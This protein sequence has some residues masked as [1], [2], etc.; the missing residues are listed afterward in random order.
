MHCVFDGSALQPSPAPDAPAAVEQPLSYLISSE[1]PFAVRPTLRVAIALCA[2]LEAIHRA[3]RVVGTLHPRDILVSGFPPVDEQTPTVRIVEK[4]LSEKTQMTE[5][6]TAYLSPEVAR[7]QA[8]DPRSDVYSVGAILYEMLSG[9]SPR[10]AAAAPRPQIPTMLEE[11]IRHSMAVDM[12]ARQSSIPALAIEL[13]TALWQVERVNGQHAPAPAPPK[14]RFEGRSTDSLLG[15]VIAGRYRLLAKLGESGLGTVFKSESA[16]LNRPVAINV[17]PSELSQDAVFI[18]R[19][20]SE[21]QA[22][23]RL[24]HPHAAAIYDFG[25]TRDGYAYLVSELVWGEPLSAILKREGPLPLV[26]ALNIAAQIAEAVETAHRLGLSHRSLKPGRVMVSRGERDADYVKVLGFGLFKMMP[27]ITDDHLT[28]AGVVIAAPEYMAPEQLSGEM[29]DA[30]SDI[31]SLAT[32]LYEMLTGRLPFEGDSL[33]VRAVRQMA[34]EPVSLRK[35]APHVGR[36]IEKAVMKGLAR[37]PEHRQASVHDFWRELEAAARAEAIDQ[38]DGVI[39][40]TARQSKSGRF[41]VVA[42][43]SAF[44]SRP[45]PH[46]GSLLSWDSKK[47]TT[48]LL[49]RKAA[50]F[51]TNVGLLFIL[52]IVLGLGS[53]AL[54]AAMLNMAA[55]ILLALAA[56]VWVWAVIVLVHKL[57]KAPPPQEVTASPAAAQLRPQYADLPALNEHKTSQ[58]VAELRQPVEQ[59]AE[60]EATKKCPTCG[61][62]LPLAA[63]FCVL[64][65][66]PVGADR[67]GEAESR[68]ALNKQCRKCGSQYAFTKKYCPRDGEQLVA[69]AASAG[70]G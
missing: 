31:Y 9:Q 27:R 58:P 67:I 5:G 65:G 64:D 24:T 52:A 48:G 10:H 30:R 8:A 14:P 33:Q 59:P 46:S 61:T 34:G 4:A 41:N 56:E 32:I 50:A 51:F 11:I 38:L 28:P 68:A 44:L 25:I 22:A 35:L 2:A 57:R 47:K 66:T 45:E 29:T 23:I 16:T 54:A 15:Q 70:R 43:L 63:R 7:L 42:R 62:G 17:F 40:S 19:F 60:R 18:A 69:V 13:Q 20:K 26:R 53:A 37:Q 1:A 39:H 21:A 36:R 3:G 49:K 55:L 12:A 6:A